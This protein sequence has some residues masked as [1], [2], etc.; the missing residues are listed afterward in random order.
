MR[1]LRRLAGA[2]ALLFSAAG[3]LICTAGIIGTWLAY[4][5]VSEK[6]ETISAKLEAGFERVT[7]VSANVRAA[8]ANARE[9]VA[10]MRLESTR[11]EDKGGKDRLA[12]R[13]LRVLIEQRA[14]PRIDNMGG[15]L[16]TL[17]D[18]AVAVSSML[19]S[20]PELAPAMTQRLDADQ[21]KSRADDMQ[22]VAGV[23]HQL[24]AALADGDREI[25]RNDVDSA[26]GDVDLVLQRCQTALEQWQSDL[27][28]A[29][30]N[31]AR[32]HARI[33]GWLTC[34]AIAVTVLF[35]WI[36][37]GQLS[38]FGRALRWCFSA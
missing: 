23:L 5:R 29:R 32:F 30:E 21:L 20:V 25:S 37:A 35:A 1:L 18:A 11:L 24:D 10:D 27:D 26:A 7:S 12:A 16:A 13:T 31:V 28:G 9:D 15:R 3:V 14:G 38:L 36:G 6:L 2:I 4:Q 33:R 19:D 22:R 17:A 8:V 34:M